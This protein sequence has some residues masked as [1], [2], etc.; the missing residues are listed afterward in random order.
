MMLADGRVTSGYAPPAGPTVEDMFRHLT[1]G[2]LAFDIGAAAACW[3]FAFLTYTNGIAGNLLPLTGMATALALRRFSPALALGIAW[4]TSLI[5][6]S[7]AIGPDI[8]NLAILPVLY[9]TARYG[10]PPVKWAGLGS[11]GA[12]ALVVAAYTSL[13][14]IFGDQFG[15]GNQIF[16]SLPH[17]ITASV[18]VFFSA[19][20]VFA[21]SWTFGLL[22]R[23]WSRAREA[24]QAR[25]L[26]ER[27]R[28]DAQR[29][30]VVEQERN[31]IARDM[32]DVVA[33]SLAVVIA[34]AD[35]ARY[36][37]AENP[38]AV[39]AALTTIS[40]IAREALGDVR[41]LLG[42]LRHSQDEVPQ[43]VLADLD[44]LFE[45]FR[46]SGLPVDFEEAGTPQPLATGAQL[47]VY[48]IV[49]EA[50]TNA[51]RHGDSPGRATVAFRWEADE[52]A[53][54][55]TSALEEGNVKPA[56]S[57]GHGL[58]GMTE[59][60]VLAGGTLTAEPHDGSFMVSATIPA[61]QHEAQQETQG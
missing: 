30:I 41:I 50:L 18:I 3:V 28:I 55:V 11:T 12:G 10:V 48:R 23:T 27:Q 26:A 8:S 2:Q 60:A 36:A 5:Q 44:R 16:I 24:G 46:A 34:Q 22:A 31:R 25:I 32:H 33:H 53:L 35:G 17:A 49:Q 58:A 21:L 15:D 61:A 37:R 47:A 57:A 13:A 20:S 54:E 7:F 43:P 42:Q 1:P 14:T 19:F 39:D 45:Q 29:S 9:A 38:E 52:L 4:V 6:V 40:T 59:R 56:T 51:L